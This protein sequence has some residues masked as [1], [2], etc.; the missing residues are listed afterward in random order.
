MSLLQ[1]LAQAHR[2]SPENEIRFTLK[3][4]LAGRRPKDRIRILDESIKMMQEEKKKIK[5][6]SI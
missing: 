5:S 6:K 2:L 4:Q 3:A 1:R